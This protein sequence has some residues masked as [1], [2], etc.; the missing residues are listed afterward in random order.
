MDLD[1]KEFPKMNM[2]DINNFQILKHF[3]LREFQ[4]PCCMRVI[5]HKSLLLKLSKLRQAIQEPLIINSGYRC[6][7]ENKAIGGTL[8]SYHMLGY[9]ADVTTKLMS[10]DDLLVFAEGLNFGGIGHYRTFL[11]LDVREIKS[12]WEDLL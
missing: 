3:N 8:H 4:C 10:I 6:E 9:A 1:L 2:N 7:K 5:I 11:H 12:R